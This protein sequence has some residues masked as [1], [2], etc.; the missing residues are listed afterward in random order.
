MYG[1]KFVNHVTLVLHMTPDPRSR[2]DA[3]VVQAFSIN[4]V[5][6]EQLNR[7]GFQF[8]AERADHPRIF[9]LKKTSPGS[10]KNKNRLAGV[11]IDQ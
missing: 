5:D 2:V 10:W 3:L 9:I 6:A 4:G 1:R 11:P 8:A 7:A